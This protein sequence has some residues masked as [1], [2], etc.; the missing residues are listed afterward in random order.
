[1]RLSISILLRRR[2]VGPIQTGLPRH[3]RQPCL[4]HIVAYVVCSL[5]H[6]MLYYIKYYAILY[7]IIWYRFFIVIGFSFACLFIVCGFSLCFYFI[8]SLYVILYDIIWYYRHCLR[9]PLAGEHRECLRGTVNII[10]YDMRCYTIVCYNTIY[11][12]ILYY[13][14]LY[15]SML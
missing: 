6:M 9:L 3:P 2:S 4:Y 12:T 11:Y 5:Y 1:M 13:N 15:Y 7:D 14:I 8:F 10:L